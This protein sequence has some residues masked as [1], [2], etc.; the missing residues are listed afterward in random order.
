ME[1]EV[2]HFIV[3]HCNAAVMLLSHPTDHQSMGLALSIFAPLKWPRRVRWFN[4][5]RVCRRK[6]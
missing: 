3:S 2:K 6:Q 5:G 1:R 4:H